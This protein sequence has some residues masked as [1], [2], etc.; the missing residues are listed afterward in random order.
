MKLII[1]SLITFLAHLPSNLYRLKVEVVGLRSNKGQVMVALYRDTDDFPSKKGRYK[2]LLLKPQNHTAIGV[3]E[4]LQPGKY[5]IAAILDENKSFD[6][7]K[8]IVGFPTEQYGFSNN[9]REQ[10]SAPSFQKASFDLHTDRK[11]QIKV[12]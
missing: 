3:F 10:F 2:Y 4:D 12:E 6:M 5:A 7:D 8:N 1:I 11:I 9:A